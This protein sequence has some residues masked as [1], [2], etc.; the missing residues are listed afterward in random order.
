MT[1]GHCVSLVLIVRRIKK[2]KSAENEAIREIIVLKPLEGL[3]FA[4]RVNLIIWA[5]FAVD[6]S[7]FRKSQLHLIRN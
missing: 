4:D 3:N 6:I 5:F 1:F 7:I 2:N